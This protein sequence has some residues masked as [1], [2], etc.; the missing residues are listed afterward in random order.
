MLRITKFLDGP[1]SDLS[2]NKYIK[3]KIVLFSL[4][5][6]LIGAYEI[7]WFDCEKKSTRGKGMNTHALWQKMISHFRNSFNIILNYLKEK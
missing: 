6:N 1:I 3:K 4:F 5:V 7:T 2:M